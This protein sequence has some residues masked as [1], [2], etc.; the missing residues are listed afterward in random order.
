MK[1]LIVVCA[2]GFSKEV[3]WLAKETNKF[4][5]VGVLD[6][7]VAIGTVIY[8]TTVIGAVDK[9]SEH[10][11]ASFVIATGNPRVRKMLAN[12]LQSIG[13][14]NFATLIHPSAVFSDSVKIGE[15][16]IICAGTILTVDIN[17][18]R[19]TIVNINST[20]GHDCQI[21]DFCTIA[22]IVSISG[23][24]TMGECVE[25]GTGASIR[26]GL[27]LEEGSM[28]GMG[29]VLTKPIPANQIFVG[30]PAQFLKA[31]Q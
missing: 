3:I 26:Q 10:L 19:H 5:V 15:G 25:V 2:G 13:V 8:G 16:S 6:D 11:D 22:P 24:V 27:S 17:I 18:G 31:F 28:L 9:A 30:N 23:N 1:K 7:K 14:K 12:K 21:G 29:G 4:H 20:V